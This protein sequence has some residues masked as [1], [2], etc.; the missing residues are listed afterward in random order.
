VPTVV[1]GDRGG[2]RS[3]LVMVFVVLAV[4]TWWLFAGN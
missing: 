4:A 3:L 2:A 1:E